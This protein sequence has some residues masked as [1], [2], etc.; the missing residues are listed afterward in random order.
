MYKTTKLFMS[1]RIGL[2]NGNTSV[3][4]HL[5]NDALSPS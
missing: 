4:L 3:P 1:S 5:F 2:H